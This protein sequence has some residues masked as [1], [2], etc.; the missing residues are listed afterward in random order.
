ML[1]CWVDRLCRVGLWSSVL[2]SDLV[3][4]HQHIWRHDWWH[5]GDWCQ[6]DAYVR[7]P[8]YNGPNFTS[9]QEGSLYAYDGSAS[10]GFSYSSAFCR[11]VTPRSI[12]DK[13]IYVYCINYSCL[14]KKTCVEEVFAVLSSSQ[15]DWSYTS[16]CRKDIRNR[17][18]P[19]AS[20]VC[21][22]RGGCNLPFL[23]LVSEGFPSL[24]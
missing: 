2:C 4:S 22:V 5:G 21:L 12:G 6:M 19:I 9:F 13:M 3:R 11:F 17:S 23:N 18:R 16:S 14:E 8:H 10:M 1:V 24:W 15:E 20:Q 7:P